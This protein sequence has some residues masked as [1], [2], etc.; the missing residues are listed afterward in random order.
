MLKPSLTYTP[1]T[2]GSM[3]LH[4][5]PGSTWHAALHPSPSLGGA[6]LSSH[7]ST[8]GVIRPSPHTACPGY[9][10]AIAQ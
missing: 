3:P 4:V 10:A 2:D 6:C 8:P 1:Q 5:H 9:G 7:V